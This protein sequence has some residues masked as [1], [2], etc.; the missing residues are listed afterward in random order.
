MIVS[1]EFTT[2]NNKFRK[3]RSRPEKPKKVDLNCSN[4][5]ETL[6]KTD[7][8]IQSEREDFGDITITESVA[9]MY[10]NL[11]FHYLCCCST[12]TSTDNV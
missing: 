8:N 11:H 1:K 10:Q 9:V 7:G 5:Y 12:D 3:K 2:V 6:Y 4:R